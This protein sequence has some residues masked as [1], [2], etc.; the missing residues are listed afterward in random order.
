MFCKTVDDFLA[1]L[2]VGSGVY[3]DTIWTD[4]EKQPVDGD[5]RTASRVAVGFRATAKV[6]LEDDGLYLE[7]FV[8]CGIDYMDATQEMA[9]SERAD[10]LMGQLGSF[11]R[12]NGLELR[13]GR[14]VIE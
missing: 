10:G 13:P 11:A 12:R 6:P 1:N 9:G 4:V 7:A 14:L 3:L 5:L 8:D 2:P